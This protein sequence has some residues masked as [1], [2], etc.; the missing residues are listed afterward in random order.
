MQLPRSYFRSIS[1]ALDNTTLYHCDSARHKVDYEGEQKE[2]QPCEG[3][4]AI[5]LLFDMKR[6]DM[7]SEVA[8]LLLRLEDVC[9]AICL[10]LFEDRLVISIRTDA[11]DPRAGRLV[12]SI[13]GRSGTAGGHD[14]M[15]G[16]RI[17][18][19]HATPAERVAELH[20]LVP[21]FLKE[22]GVAAAVGDPLLD[23]GNH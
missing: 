5:S 1:E 6:P 20:A 22:L 19:P 17:H 18:L 21:R 11:V 23:I 14:T 10:G 2:Q 16:G 15:A 3:D 4:V 7:A 13:V 8:D 12:R 9:W